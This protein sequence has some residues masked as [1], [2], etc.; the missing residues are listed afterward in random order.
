MKSYGRGRLRTRGRETRDPKIEIK[1]G[2]RNPPEE[3]KEDDK[4]SKKESPESKVEKKANDIEVE[5]IVVR[6]RG[7]G[8]SGARR[9]GALANRRTRNLLKTGNR[10][11]RL[12][13]AQGALKEDKN[14]ENKGRRRTFGRFGRRR[15]N[16]SYG[17]RRGGNLGLRKVF[18]GGLPRYIDNRRFYGLFRTE[19]KIIGCRVGYDKLGISRGFGVIEFKYS[20]D[21]YRLI[22]RTRG[23]QFKGFNFRISYKRRNN[24]RRTME[25]RENNYYE[26]RNNNFGYNRNNYRDRDDYRRNDYGRYRNDRKDFRDRRYNRGYY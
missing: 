26:N 21:A 8:T 23:R 14:K 15:N 10:R 20:R 12:Q 25:R 17:I 3:K 4:E 18:V 5:S 6:S 16:F 22:Q 13:R 9:R 7:R 19:G 11:N 2:N 1:V 24:Q